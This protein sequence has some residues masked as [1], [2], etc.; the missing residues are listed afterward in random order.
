[1]IVAVATTGAT[2]LAVAVAAAVDTGVG[3]VGEL[4]AMSLLLT[5]SWAF[6]VLVLRTEETEAFQLDEAFFVA[7]A[8]LLPPAGTVI[9]FAAAIALGN[10]VRRRPFARAAFNVGQ[11]VT[12]AGLGLV[13]MHA[14]APSIGTPLTPRV[15]A[16]TLVGAVVFLFANSALVSVIISL[17]EEKPAVR[18]FLEGLH[19]RVLVWAGG[20]ALGLLAAIGEA[21]NPWALLL[22]ALPMAALNLILREH[23]HARRQTQRAQGLVAVANQVHA[24]VAVG[25]VEDA[26]IAATKDLLHCR[27]ARIA[28]ALPVSGEIGAWIPEPESTRWLIVGDPLGFERLGKPEQKV[29]DVIAGITA[30]AMRSARLL[31]EIRHRA[32]HDPLTDLPN[33]LLFLDRLEHALASSGRHGR[34]L[35]V[36]F[37]DLDQFKVI[38]DS[39]GHDAGDQVLLGV[40]ERLKTAL[41]EEDTAAR[42]GGDEFAVLCENLDSVDDGTLIAER[43]R[44]AA[45][46]SSVAEGV[47]LGVT[48]SVGVVVV[49]P[50]SDVTAEALLQAA[51]TAMY[52]AKERGRDRVEIFDD[53][54]R[55]RA[56]ARLGIE[57]TLRRAIEESRLRVFYQPIVDMHTG[58]IVEAE[59]LLR[60]E[61]LSGTYLSPADFIEVAEESGLIVTIG[62][63]VLEEAC[64]QAVAWRKEFGDHAPQRV[65]VNFSPR[66]LNRVPLQE[67]VQTA[68]AVTGCSADM[69]AVEITETALME[70]GQQARDELDGLRQMGVTVGLDDF[71]TGYSSLAYLKRLPVSF[72]KVDRCFVAGLGH[73]H[74]DHAIV[75]AMISL[76]RSLGLSTVAE[77]VETVEQMERL[78]RLGCDRM[79]GYLFSPARPPSEWGT[80][81]AADWPWESV[82]P[83]PL[84]F[85]ARF[86]P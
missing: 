19:L 53:G 68:L 52:R 13:A 2:T 79:Q 71:G 34:R 16:A 86:R 7:M 31:E 42:L 8:L 49:E 48:A 58:R 77:G 5:A 30:E 85:L 55:N 80:L 37:L 54:L 6:P 33:K 15:L 61:T 63:R 83:E 14:I 39:L 65:A 45:S 22:G 46:G 67:T 70:A 10:L 84:A 76:G 38:N 26:V 32:I 72:L 56:F 24:A 64:R 9:G 25:N 50:D 81:L 4:V 1:M 57:T 41:R 23:A 78:H 75:D 69:L 20:T 36:M 21:T 17:N 35:A 40:A 74:E 51:D 82:L 59:A 43:V 29:L 11:T 47:E 60:V 66:Q 3:P 62:A 18:V 12:S 28:S 73:D 44:A 27:A